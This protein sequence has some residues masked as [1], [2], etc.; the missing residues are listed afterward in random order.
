M[1][2]GIVNLPLHD[3]KA[4]KWLY[5][6]MVSLLIPFSKLLYEEVGE[7]GF[8][9]KLADPFWFQ[10]LGCLVGY[11]WHS[12]GLTTVLTSALKDALAKTDIPIKIAGGKGKTAINTP[13]EINQVKWDLDKEKLIYVSRMI[14]KVD[15]AL[16]QT[17][18]QLYHHTIAFSK[19]GKWAI[20]QQGMNTQNKYARRTHFI[21]SKNLTLEPYAGLEG[22]PEENVL[23]M[24]S[25]DSLNAQKIFVEIFNNKNE[26]KHDIAQLS[27]PRHHLITINDIKNESL[28]ELLEINETVSNFEEL[29]ALRGIG[30]KA[31]RALALISELIYGERPSYEDP[32]KFSFAHGG[33]DGTPYKINKKDYD[34]DISLLNKIADKSLGEE[35]IRAFRRLSYFLSHVKT[36][37]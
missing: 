23:N 33:K 35:K 25:K 21:Y 13:N 5:K 37:E 26:L 20:I 14:A 36:I 11:D 29:A 27:F 4:P 8:L 9:N 28:R 31:I 19:D 34:E 7:E 24:T 12:S 16:V 22:V 15:T 6:R 1:R 10:S 32:V 30:R 2:T 3:G 17:N 18:Y